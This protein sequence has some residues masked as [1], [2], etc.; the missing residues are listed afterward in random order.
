MSRPIPFELKAVGDEGIFSGLASTFGNE[1]MG[2]DIVAPG[3][4]KR[5]L[6]AHTRA[7]TKVKMFRDHDPREVI[8]VWTSIQET[9]KGLE[10]TGKLTLAVQ[11]AQETLALLKDGALEGLS[12]GYRTV[13]ATKDRKTGARVL[14]QLDLHEISLVSIPMNQEARVVAV[15]ADEIATEREYEAFLRDAGWSR[16]R[17]KVLAKGFRPAA[18]AQRDA[19][20]HAVTTL[21]QR[22]RASASLITQPGIQT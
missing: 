22:I 12:I 17:A 5:S 15:K 4:F 11:K 19:D 13:H 6:A 8:G 7:G 18:A 3:A 9:A 16:E 2:G 1:D 14:E 20:R 10:V 21:A